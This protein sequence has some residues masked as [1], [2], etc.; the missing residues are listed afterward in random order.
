M[1]PG[2]RLQFRAS[3]W[4]VVCC[5]PPSGCPRMDHAKPSD[6]RSHCS[7]VALR[8]N[9]MAKGPWDS[10]TRFFVVAIVYSRRT[11]PAHPRNL[12]IVLWSIPGISSPLLAGVGGTDTA[13]SLDRHPN[14]SCRYP[15]A[16]PHTD[17]Q[18]SLR[19]SWRSFSYLRVDQAPSTR[20]PEGPTTLMLQIAQLPEKETASLHQL[21]EGGPGDEHERRPGREDHAKRFF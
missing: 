8:F 17:A 21:S 4:C 14:R 9:R 10:G 13:G 19:R 2:E 15:I 5:K 7:V 6:V 1:V 3:Q 18:F 12:G 16:E 20:N 11:N